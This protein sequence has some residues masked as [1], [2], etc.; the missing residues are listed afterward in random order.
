MAKQKALSVTILNRNYPP[1]KGI[2]GESASDLAHFLTDRSVDVHVIH[3]DAAYD[4][5][6]HLDTSI[7]HV[8]TIHTFYNGKKKLFRLL[9][10]LYEGLALVLKARKHTPSVIICMTDPPLLNFWASLLLPKNKK[11]I[12]WAMDLYPEAFISGK[13]VSEKNLFYRIIDR[14]LKKNP[15]QHIISLGSYQSKL[16]QNK[17]NHTPACTILPCGIFDKNDPKNKNGVLPTWAQQRHKIYLGY[18]GNIGEAHSTDFLLSV[19]NHFNPEKFHLV[20]S[21]YGSNAKMVEEYAK[22]R[23][24]ISIVDS[25]K[26]GQLQYIDIHLASLT[27]D[28]VSVSVPSKTVSSVCAGSAFLYQG[29]QESDNWELLQNAG[30]IIDSALGLDEKVNYFLNSVTKESLELKKIAATKLATELNQLKLQAFNEIFLKI[31]E[32]Q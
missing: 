11:W 5:G 10:N 12:L 14:I 20:L 4:G 30:W 26:R 9:A 21:L 24:G 25:V 22:D 16:L 1:G 18:C 29:E 27:K 17:F 13:L 2:T 3:V 23:A 19:I 8:D 32:L 7:G 28:W 31:Q 6:H 15:P